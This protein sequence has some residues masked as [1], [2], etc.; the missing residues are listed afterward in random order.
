MI[1]ISTCEATMNHLGTGSTELVSTLQGMEPYSAQPLM[2]ANLRP[3]IISEVDYLVLDYRFS[4]WHCTL[5]L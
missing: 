1:T 3:C 4:S 2:K 5:A